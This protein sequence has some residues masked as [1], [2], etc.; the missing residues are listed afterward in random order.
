MNK[1]LKAFTFI[2]LLVVIAIIAILVVL[3]ILALNSARARARDSQRKTNLNS[4]HTG[5]EIY[6][7]S[8]NHYPMYDLAGVNTSVT[9]YSG[10]L[11]TNNN[12]IAEN[13]NCLWGFR[14]EMDVETWTEDPQN[15]SSLPEPNPDEEYKYGYN[16]D[17]T[18]DTFVLV[19]TLETGDLADDPW[20]YKIGSAKDT[21]TPI[22]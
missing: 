21:L 10:N 20:S 18:A 17:V 15:G 13:P 4:V 12:E 9:C 16:S 3:I 14:D 5:L 6:N 2:E 22:H 19:C 11:D 7:D 1:K 8:N